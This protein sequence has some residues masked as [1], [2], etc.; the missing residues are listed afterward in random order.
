MTSLAESRAATLLIR[1]SP[2][3]ASGRSTSRIMAEV[4]LALLPVTAFAVWQFGL[5]ALVTVLTAVASCLLAERW[6]LKSQRHPGLFGDHSALVTGL[7][8][9]LILPPN[10]ALWMTAAGGFLAIG[11]GKALFGGLGSNPF[12]PALVSRA[13]LQAAFPVAMTTWLVGGAADRFASLPSSTLTAPFLTPAYDGISG[14]TPLSAWKFEHVAA[15]TM[16]LFTGTVTG[17]TGETSALLILLAGLWLAWRRM[18]SIRIPLA[19]LGT[20]ALLSAILHA[21]EPTRFASAPFMLLSGGLML[22]AWFMATDM[23]TAPV[24]GNGR[25]VYGAVIGALVVVIRAFGGMPEGVMYAILLGNA[26]TP[27]LDRWTQPR[28]YGHRRKA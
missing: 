13:V 4:A 28:T 9:G 3:I 18:L 14:P 15:G 24:T 23:V 5:A 25:L 10:L 12:N 1:S 20:V 27:W 7:L 8:L 16:D 21:I 11:V 22:G 6:M 17:S 19:I 2:H 26:L